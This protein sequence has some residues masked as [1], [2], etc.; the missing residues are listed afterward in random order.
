MGG[1]RAQR[2][3]AGNAGRHK[4][5]RAAGEALEIPLILKEGAEV[6]GI[7]GDSSEVFFHLV[8]GVRGGKPANKE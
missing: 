5:P 2:I 1:Q 4:R 8:V 3:F 6:A 7:F